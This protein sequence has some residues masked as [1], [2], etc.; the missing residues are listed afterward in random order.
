MNSESEDA[1]ASD[2]ANRRGDCGPQGPERLRVWL[3]PAMCKPV[4]GHVR[5]RHIDQDVLRTLRVVAA[6]N[7]YVGFQV[8]LDAK[9][10]FVLSLSETNWLH[11]LGNCPRARVRVDDEFGELTVEPSIV[12]FVEGDDGQDWGEYLDTSSRTQAIAYRTNAVYVRVFVPPD[13]RP[14]EH[15]LRV[16]VYTRARGFDEEVTAWEG[17]ALVDVRPVTL[18]SPRQFSFHLDLWQHLTCLARHHGVALWSEEHFT[19]INRYFASL[20]A[21]GQ[22]ALTVVA[23]EVP[24]AGQQCFRDRKYPSYLFEHSVIRVYRHRLAPGHASVLAAS[25]GVGAAATPTESAAATSSSVAA[26]QAS[27]Q[28]PLPGVS[29][30][31]V[32]RSSGG[33]MGSPLR[34]P[35]RKRSDASNSGSPD[36]EFGAPGAGPLP[37]PSYRP[38][39]APMATGSPAIPDP[40]DESRRKMPRNGSSPWAGAAAEGAG[41]PVDAGSPAGG[42]TGDQPS[43]LEFD[44]T[45][46]DKL[47]ALASTHGMDREIEVFGLLSVWEDSE[48]GFGSVLVDGPDT[49]V[50]VPCTNVETGCVGF[51]RTMEEL[52]AYVTAL[53]EHFASLGVLERVRICADEPANL[54]AFRERLRFLRE[55][56]PGFRYKVAI[57]HFEFME[58]APPEV[59]DC[60]PY[61][62]LACR[63]PGLT[64]KLHQRVRSKGGRM[65]W[66]VCCVPD[67]PN[68]FLSSPL[69]EAQVR[70]LHAPYPMFPSS[71]LTAHTI[72][73]R[74]LG[75]R[76]CTAG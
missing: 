71:R 22:K 28:N 49:F 74:S 5:S 65:L 40:A 25:T 8:Q 56:A 51:L 36:E 66:Y 33:G 37:A 4:W 55:A 6:R 58:H 60:V 59:I 75:R 42:V 46:L 68:S 13:A 53:Y 44:F 72:F 54:A 24:W 50:R 35:S 69:V 57:N 73:P 45:A 32:S 17:R 41:V 38:G 20:A 9:E 27:V 39:A 14:R 31:A 16:R 1:A 34:L 52:R 30:A 63:D 2:E 70:A 76:S 18:P 21:L 10:D 26:A 62:P 3:Q 48:F 15:P 7:E 43:R 11:A 47:I 67:F 23:S 61:L 64:M 29:V 19:V 12:G